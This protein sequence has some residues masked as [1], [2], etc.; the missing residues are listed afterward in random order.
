LQVS[1]SWAIVSI[2]RQHVT[3]YDAEGWIQSSWL[4]IGRSTK[5]CRPVLFSSTLLFAV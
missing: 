4:V 2:K 3:I 5:S 1:R